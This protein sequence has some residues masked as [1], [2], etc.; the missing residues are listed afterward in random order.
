[1]PLKLDPI[2][3]GRLR[4]RHSITSPPGESDA[5]T[6]AVGWYQL[7][8]ACPETHQPLRLRIRF[9]RDTYGRESSR[10]IFLTLICEP[11]P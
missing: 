1:M 11:R 2:E 8:D 4:I 7:M 3:E 9:E 6:V 10:R 5:Q